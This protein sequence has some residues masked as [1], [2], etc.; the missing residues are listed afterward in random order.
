MRL[1]VPPN[2]SDLARSGSVSQEASAK[3]VRTRSGLFGFFRPQKTVSPLTQQATQALPVAKPRSSPQ[4]LRTEDEGHESGIPAESG[5]AWSTLPEHLIESVMEMLQTEIPPPMHHSSK[6]SRQAQFAVSSV[7]KNWRQ[8]GRRAFFKG[9]WDSSGAITHP[10]Q[11]FGLSPENVSNHLVKCVMKRECASTRPKAVKYTL[12]LGDKMSNSTFLMAA[13]QGSRLDIKM[14]LT[15]SCTGTPCA[16]IETNLLGTRYEVVLDSTVQPFA[17]HEATHSHTAPMT[18]DKLPSVERAQSMQSAQSGNCSFDVPVVDLPSTSQAAFAP[19]TPPTS[20][21]SFGGKALLSQAAAA[22]RT[23]LPPDEPVSS[24]SSNMPTQPETTRDTW[25]ALFP[26]PAA[27]GSFLS[28]FRTSQARPNAA[29]QS[30]FA[31]M[32]SDSA[33]QQLCANV[34][35]AV[36]SP[37]ASSSFLAR[38]QSA[39]QGWTSGHAHSGANLLPISPSSSASDALFARAWSACAEGSGPVEGSSESPPCSCHVVPKSVGGVQY[40]TRI[41]GFMRPRRM[42]VSLPDPSSLACFDTT[43][44]SSCCSRSSSA[45][46]SNRL[47]ASL[48]VTSAFIADGLRQSSSQ[49]GAHEPQVQSPSSPSYPQADQETPETSAASSL[50]HVAPMTPGIPTPSQT[51]SQS[52]ATPRRPSTSPSQKGVELQNKP[53]HWNDTLRCWCLNFRGRVKLASV[54]NFQLIKAEDPNKAIVMQFGK[55]DSYTY[56]MDYN[57]AEITAIQAFAI[58]LSTF[59][60]KLLL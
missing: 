20:C 31:A 22:T 28:R 50:T 36:T 11:L 16:R 19:A 9:L 8:I 7:S 42:K 49:T 29:L 3:S 15:S 12:R 44:S 57:P 53:P 25:S 17:Q 54:K 32:T 40:K 6:A 46:L 58:S 33:E 59:D 5:S 38:C 27:S 51:D 10:V 39:T 2:A 30:P 52:S 21:D 14:Y 56:I 45:Q 13:L 24:A 35:T 48:L 60:T 23:N 47:P 55:V 34:P 4:T 26:S 18:F 41:R 37:S 43:A 1:S